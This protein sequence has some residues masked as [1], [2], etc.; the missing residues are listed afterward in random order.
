MGDFND[1]PTDR[2]IQEGLGAICGLNDVQIS[3][4]MCMDQAEG[5]GSYQYN[6]T[7]DYLDQFLV[8]H[9]LASKVESAQAL[10]NK[11]LLFDHPKFGPSPDKTYSGLRYKGG[12]SDHLPIVLRFN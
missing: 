8:S 12:Y 7:W 3:A 10:W 6:G 9:E 2:S 1:T 4:L 11:H 5:Q